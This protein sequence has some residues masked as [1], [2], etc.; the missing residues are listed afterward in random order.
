[1]SKF[2]LAGRTR[3]VETTTPG[4]RCGGGFTPTRAGKGVSLCLFFVLF[5]T[6]NLG[7]AHGRYRTDSSAA[8]P[9]LFEMASITSWEGGGWTGMGA[10]RQESR[11]T[12][13]GPT[14]AS[15]LTSRH[16]ASAFAGS[17]CPSHVLTCASA[18]RRHVMPTLLHLN[19]G[20]VKACNTHT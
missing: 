16:A 10:T 20:P 11:T 1:M 4:G 6:F 8:K 3:I 19:D 15:H 18:P 9:A 7:L 5:F 13:C 12:A 14:P 2:P 17:Q